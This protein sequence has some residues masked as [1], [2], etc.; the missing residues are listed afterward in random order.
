MGFLK[1]KLQY[2]KFNKRF[3]MDDYKAMEKEMNEGATKIQA[4]FKGKKA[5]REIEQ[6]KRAAQLIQKIVRGY[7]GFKKF[8]ELKEQKEI[9]MSAVKI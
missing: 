4:S 2:D 3:T 9:E 5:R 8:K 6:K 1:D 7:Q